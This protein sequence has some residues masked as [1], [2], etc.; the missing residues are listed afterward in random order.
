MAEHTSG[1]WVLQRMGHQAF[2]VICEQPGQYGTFL[3]IDPGSGAPE[4]LNPED[5]DA[6]EAN[7]RLIAAA[8]EMLAALKVL[9]ASE[10]GSWAGERW[11]REKEEALG[12]ARAV[13]ARAEGR[14]D[15]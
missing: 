11:E 1:P 15:E 3:G 7:A 9:V 5:Q 12:R 14:A 10:A 6:F 2:D 8:P 13:I 4:V